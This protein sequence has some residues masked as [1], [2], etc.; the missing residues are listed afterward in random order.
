MDFRVAADD[1]LL[2][3]SVRAFVE[4]EVNPRW[5]QIDRED[6]IP[7]DIIAGIKRLG[8]FG[9]SVPPEYGG[10]GLSVLQKALVHEQLG[11]GPWGLASFVSVHT[12]IGCVGIVRFGS[13]KQKQ[14]YLPKMATGEWLGSFALTEP[15]AGSDAGALKTR[16][17]RQ[18][19]DW[20]LHG[21]KIFITN[22][23]LAHQFFL[24]A[25]TDRGISAFIVDRDSPGLSIGSVFDTL[26]HQG[27]QISEVILDGCRVPADALVGE[28]GQG[29][30]Y[31]KRTLAEGRTTLA[32]RCVGA[33]QKAL[34]LALEYAEQRRTF[35]KPLIEHQSIAFRLAQMSARIEAARLLVYRSAWLLDQ[36][37]PAIRE[38]S[39]AKLVAAENA[40][41]T[42]DDALQIF[43]GNGYVRGEY[44]IERIWRDV[45]VAR[46]YDGSSEVQQIV[47]AQRLRKGDL[48]T[49]G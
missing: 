4:Q 25:R 5:Q 23:P 11:R 35:G 19:H 9:M 15:E 22:A 32:A 33:A 6:R 30:E 14:R 1:Q 10:L 37:S 44:M 3:E 17:E 41:Q 34:E 26:G 2:A 46:V 39:T 7:A 21:R 42:V 12:G 27:S 13:A 40:W 47:I 20:V 31:A 38:S 18:G 29:F 28:E 49:R 45:R 48:E 36:G 8:L 43:G 16:A 24:F